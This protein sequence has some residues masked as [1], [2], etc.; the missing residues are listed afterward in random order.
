MIKN[1]YR[2]LFGV[3]ILSFSTGYYTFSPQGSK[4]HNVT[5]KK[6]GNQWTVIVDTTVL[7]KKTELKVKKNERIIWTVEGS[8]AYFQFSDS[9]LFDPEGQEDKLEDGYVK[10]LKAGKKLRL[11]VR[12]LPPMTVTYAIFC[13]KDNKFAI[14]SS[15]PKIIIQR[16]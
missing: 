5:V 15:P 11:K 16:G 12:D 7:G 3:L 2:L 10:Y 9:T 6:I 8:D 1:L 13:L 14:Q 4:T